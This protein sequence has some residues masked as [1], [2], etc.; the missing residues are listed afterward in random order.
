[1]PSL[2]KLHE[3]NKWNKHCARIHGHAGLDTML[4]I[5]LYNGYSTQVQEK[6]P[7]NLGNWFPD[8]S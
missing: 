5:M 4:C 2:H 6:F 8:G 7:G 3:G 1:M